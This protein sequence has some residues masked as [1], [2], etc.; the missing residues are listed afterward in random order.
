M[1]D[2]ILVTC[3]HGGNRVPERYGAMF[4]GWKRRL[5]TH[6]G[7]DPGALRMARQLSRSFKAPLVA[8]TVTR[9]LVDLNR[10]VGHRNLYSMASRHV[11]PEERDRILRDHYLPYRTRVGDLVAK[12]VGRGYRVVHISS[13]SFTPRLG[14]VVRSAD[15]GLLY[16]PARPGEFKL[17]ELW[18]GSLRRS[19]PGLRIRRNY[20]YLG[21]QDG[22]T[23]HL[24]RRYPPAAYVGVE[25][26]LNQ[27]LVNGTKSRWLRGAV[28]ESLRRV[29][30]SEQWQGAAL[31]HVR[32]PTRG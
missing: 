27:A 6:R 22:L 1:R 7:F 9:L 13:H 14:G 8:S 26:E 25:L 32:A 31:H 2:W 23:S 10:S 12:A 21:K 30:A 29:I 15:I 5:S 11:S 24:R 28:V 3:E 17:G 16:N 20:P 18:K 19:A 4:R